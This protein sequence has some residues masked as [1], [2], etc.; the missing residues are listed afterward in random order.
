MVEGNTAVQEA[1]L[2]GAIRHLDERATA[3]R[4]ELADVERARSSLQQVVARESGFIV[5][6][7][8]Q[9]IIAE[10]GDCRNQREGLKWIALRKGGRVRVRDAARLIERSSLTN[11][12]L[13]SIRATLLRYVKESPDWTEEGDGYFGLVDGDL[14][15]IMERAKP[16]VTVHS[17]DGSVRGLMSLEEGEGDSAA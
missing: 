2:V 7:D 15:A 10:I 4:Q 5:A 9:S 13:T 8:D 3:L 11:A 6:T 14:A 17:A 1:V 12:K 16:F